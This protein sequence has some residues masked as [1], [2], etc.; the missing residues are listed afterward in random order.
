MTEEGARRRVVIVGGEYNQGIFT[1]TA[2]GAVYDPRLDH[3]TL[4]DPPAGWGYILP[5]LRPFGQQPFAAGA[6][7]YRPSGPNSFTPS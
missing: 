6:T 3:W 7:L 1:L 5:G 2:Q 4:L